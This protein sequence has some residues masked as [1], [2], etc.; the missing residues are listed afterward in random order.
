[1]AG[2][3]NNLTP[4]QLG[5]VRNPN[6]RPKGSKNLSTL[7]KELENEQFDWSKMPVRQSAAVTALG[8]PWKAITY[9]A[10]VNAL[11]GDTKAAEW[12]RKAGYG[13]KVDVTSNGETLKT[14]L[15]EFVGENDKDISPQE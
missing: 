7:I 11:K 14:A 13:D 12:L 1:M 8:S 9:V 4:P 6:G 10:V 2:V 3:N 15:V 5:E